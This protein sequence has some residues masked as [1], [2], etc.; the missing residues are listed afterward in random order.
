MAEAR[1]LKAVIT[2]SAENNLVVYFPPAVASAAACK[3][4]DWSQ[5]PRLSIERSL[6]NAAN[7]P[8]EQPQPYSEACSELYAK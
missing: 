2:T 4:Q 1:A 7:L 3:A 6:Y 5:D 8:A